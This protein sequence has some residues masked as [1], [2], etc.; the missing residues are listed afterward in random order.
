MSEKKKTEK[1][2][3]VQQNKVQ[4]LRIQVLRT[5]VKGGLSDGNGFDD[6]GSTVDGY[7]RPS[8]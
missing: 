1:I 3:T 5:R 6:E 4:D 8:W 7:C 2:Q